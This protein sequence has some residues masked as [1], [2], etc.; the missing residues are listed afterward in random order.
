MRKATIQTEHTIAFLS[1]D[2]LNALYTQ[3]EWAA[4]LVQELSGTD[5]KLVPVHVQTCKPQGILTTASS[6]TK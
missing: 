4:A 6:H 5:G 2:Y 1:P 3:P